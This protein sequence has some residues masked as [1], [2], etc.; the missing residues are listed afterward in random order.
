[1]SAIRSVLSIFALAGLFFRP[2]FAQL[3]RIEQCLPIPSFGSE[4]D[5]FRAEVRRDDQRETSP[6]G[7]IRRIRFIGDLKMPQ[8]FQQQLIKKLRTQRFEDGDRWQDEVSERI[9]GAWQEHGYFKAQVAVSVRKVQQ[10]DGYRGY[11]LIATISEGKRYRL[12]KIKFYSPKGPPAA[13][14]TSRLRSEFP[15]D[16]GAIFSTAAV[17]AGLDRLTQLYANAGYIRFTGAPDVVLDDDKKQASVLID[18]DEGDIYTIREIKIL[19]VGPTR[20]NPILKANNVAEGKPYS[21]RNLEA[22]W[23]EAKAFIPSTEPIESV[24]EISED[25]VRKTVTIQ[26][27]ARTCISPKKRTAAVIATR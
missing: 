4:L 27:D 1:M 5:D 20:L 15:I 9:L 25:D 14:D 8:I 16:D 19:G 6:Q 21:S 22:F 24:I 12:R 2:A 23:R 26:I 11:D 10:H 17:R 7:R 18:L 3:G 13:Y